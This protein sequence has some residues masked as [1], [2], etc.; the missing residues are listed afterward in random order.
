MSKK[1]RF[2]GSFDKKY[3]KCAQTLLK[4]SSEHLYHI[5][6]PLETKLYSRKSLLYTCPILGLLVNT[7]AANEKYLFPNKDNLTIPIQMLFIS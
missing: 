6:W 2:R 4:S 7:L 5:L 3:G 1:S